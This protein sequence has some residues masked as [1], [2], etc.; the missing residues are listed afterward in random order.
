MLVINIVQCKVEHSKL[1]TG[2]V[3]ADQVGY[4]KT[5]IILGLID[6]SPLTP[7]TDSHGHILVFQ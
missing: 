6:S 1:V 4:G 2:G 5:A 3:L 7:P